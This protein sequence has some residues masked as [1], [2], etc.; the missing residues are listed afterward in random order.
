[1]KYIKETTSALIEGSAGHVGT[2]K[3]VHRIPWQQYFALAFWFSL[4]LLGCAF[5]RLVCHFGI[6][7]DCHARTDSIKGI[8]SLATLLR[9]GFIL[10]VLTGINQQDRF[11][12]LF[13][14]NPQHPRGVIF[15]A[16]FLATSPVFGVLGL[17]PALQ[18]FSLESENMGNALFQVLLVLLAL[19]FVAL[20]AFH[21]W[22]AYEH[23]PR[24]AFLTYTI[25][26]IIIWALYIAYFFAS[27]SDDYAVFHLHHYMVGFILAV[28]AE[29]NHPVSVLLL[30]IGS[31]LMVQ[32]IAAYHADPLIYRR[33]W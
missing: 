30:A 21:F 2:G 28:L 14:F 22:F 6:P 33:E 25:T 29:F 32:G 9:M 23:N 20:V 5:T 19:G 17:I 31:G 3:Y 27:A 26:R 24:P 7:H 11:S 13:Y 12:Y 16:V 10:A 1:M 4:L 15:I 8:D 18:H